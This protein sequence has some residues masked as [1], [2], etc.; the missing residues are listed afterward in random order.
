MRMN[1]RRFFFH[2]LES[3]TDGGAGLRR[4]AGVLGVALAGVYIA[5]IKQGSLV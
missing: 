1:G 2:Q 4:C 3:H 5:E